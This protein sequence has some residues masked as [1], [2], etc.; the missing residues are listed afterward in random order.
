MNDEFEAGALPT[1]ERKSSGRLFTLILLL[2]VTVAFAFA[3][4]LR[5]PKSKG[6]STAPEIR[7]VGWLNGPGPTPEALHGKVIVLDAWAFWCGPCRMAAPELIKLHNRYAEQGVIFLGL[8]VEG[9]DHDRENRSFLSATKITWPNGYGAVDTLQ[10]LEANLIPQV[11]VI[12]RDY[13][14][15]WN[16]IQSSEPIETAIERALAQQPS[17]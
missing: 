16:S 17:S 5:Q 15:I 14:I 6:P 7:V 1:P 4:S 2:V 11:W 10:K 13:N 3:F 12:D 8:T 9:I